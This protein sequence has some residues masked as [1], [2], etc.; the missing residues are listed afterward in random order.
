MRTT[1]REQSG[2][3]TTGSGRSV[4]R[5]CWRT[6]G[7]RSH[8]LRLPELREEG[9]NEGRNGRNGAGAVEVLTWALPL[10]GAGQRRGPCSSTLPRTPPSWLTGGRVTCP[11][12]SRSAGDSPTLLPRSSLRLGRLPSLSHV[13]GELGASVLRG[14][15]TF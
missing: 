8:C 11:W 4:N 12:V 14:C 13:L 3:A 7:K 6:K 1:W 5:T 2:S 15:L 9:R 10:A